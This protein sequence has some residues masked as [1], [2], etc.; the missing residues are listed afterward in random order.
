MSLSKSH[1]VESSADAP[2]RHE[3]VSQVDDQRRAITAH[4]HRYV[5]GMQ[6][7]DRVAAAMHHAV[8]GGHRWRALL[9]M[10]I[11][12]GT[13][14]SWTDVLDCACAVELIH[15]S[16]LLVDDLPC[17]DNADTRRGQPACHHLY[18]DATTI[19]ASHALVALAD[20][21]VAA[22]ARVRTS[23]SD[24]LSLEFANVRRDLIKGQMLETALAE[25]DVAPDEK[26]LIRL[27]LLKGSLFRAAGAVA[28]RVAGCPPPVF[29]AILTFSSRIGIM[30]Q[31]ADDIA[32]ATLTPAAIGKGVRMDAHKRNL[33]T[34]QGAL[35]ARR[36][37]DTLRADV[38]GSLDGLLPAPWFVTRLL[39]EMRDVGVSLRRP[40]AEES[41]VRG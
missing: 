9:A 26:A 13:G 37:L 1:G 28:A 29:K 15:S 4:L 34:V 32:D 23:R 2:S 35:A 6:Y 27:C 14:G 25:G 7:P 39:E 12:E 30:Y 16:S 33:L 38:L 18:G 10:S 20:R 24:R 21:I 31:I 40:S 8:A 22:R 36:S 5:D 3:R 41:D 17:I 11:Y 19:Y